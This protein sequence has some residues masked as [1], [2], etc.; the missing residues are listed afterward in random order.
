MKKKTVIVDLDGTLY[1]QKPVQL[2]MGLELCF[3]YIL[4]IYKWRE[5]LILLRYRKQ[6]NTSTSFN[7]KQF[8]LSN[9]ISVSKIKKLVD[10]WLILKP[11]KWI[12]LFADNKLIKIL[13]QIQK[14][15]DVIVYLIIRLQ[16]N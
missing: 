8:A 3:Y 13:R 4:H 7:I 5:F 16:K 9:N 14:Q 12:K 2:C 15:M 10:L 1:F 11:L 6:H